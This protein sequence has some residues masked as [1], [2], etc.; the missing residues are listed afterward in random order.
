MN[1]SGQILPPA[2]PGVSE[3][4]PHPPRVRVARSEQMVRRVCGKIRGG[5]RSCRDRIG[6]GADTL[7][8]MDKWDA[9]KARAL[10]ATAVRIFSDHGPHDDQLGRDN[11]AACA[12]ATFT[13]QDRPGYVGWL[14]LWIQAGWRIPRQHYEAEIAEAQQENPAYY[15]AILRDVETFGLELN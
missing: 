2:R 5:T 6:L 13:E 9:D 4:T 7:H 10:Q 15:E 12:V 1:D 14:R 8:D 11:C 3:G